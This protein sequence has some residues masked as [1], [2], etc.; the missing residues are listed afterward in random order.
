MGRLFT[1]IL[2]SVSLTIT[3]C[4][5]AWLFPRKRPDVRTNR[6][7]PDATPTPATENIPARPPVDGLPIA[8]EPATPSR[9]PV[10]ILALSGGGSYGAYTAG[11]LNGWSRSNTRPEFDVV[12]G[13]STGAL[14]APLAFLGQKY[15]FEMRRVY[16]EVGQRDVFRIRYW[17]TIPFRDSVATSAP[18]RRIVENGVTDEM[19]IAIAAEH[20]KGRRLYV[21]TTQLDSRRAVVWDLGAIAERGAGSRQLIH[22][23]LLAS[24]SV[25]GVFPP[26]PIDLELDGKPYTEMHVDGGVTAPVFVPPHVLQ[27]AGPGANLYVIVAGK[28]FPEVARVQ[29]RVLKVLSASGGALMHAHT[30][31]DVSN[32][33]HM[34][35]LGGLNFH[36]VSLRQEFAAYD[37][38]IGFD[39]NEMN[40]LYVEGVRVG[41]AG[42]IWQNGPP[43]RSPGDNA[44]I[45]TGPRF[46]TVP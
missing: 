21:A 34:A 39:P 38:G 27:D 9:K 10:N 40:R 7:H 1:L 14:I 43:E 35:Q 22:D 19:V 20:R 31:S 42:P 28:F 2:V 6:N 41:I 46:R 8:V 36:V 37:T 11:V 24:C 4:M 23:I 17:A 26:V 44:E 25:P 33:Y 5:P 30:R 12:T 16:N 3:G 45:R 15:D 18:L 13:I 29:P 32:L